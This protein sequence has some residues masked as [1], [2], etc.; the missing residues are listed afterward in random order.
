[1]DP[2][3][4]PKSFVESFMCT[5]REEE[6][7][8]SSENLIIDTSD[9]FNTISNIRKY[10]LFVSFCLIE[11]LFG[12]GFTSLYILYPQ[13]ASE[14]GIVQSQFNLII[15]GAGV[16]GL[17][18]GLSYQFIV[19]FLHRRT[20]LVLFTIGIGISQ[21]YFAFVTLFIRQATLEYILVFIAC[22]FIVSFQT[23]AFNNYLATT[24]KL[25]PETI[26]QKGALLF[27]SL[28][29][30]IM[31]GP[32]GFTWV[33]STTNIFSLPF[34]ITGELYIILGIAIAFLMPKALPE[35]FQK[36]KMSF[37][38]RDL[39]GLRII[40]SIFNM[41]FGYSLNRIISSGLSL[42]LKN[43]LNASTYVIS[44][45]QTTGGLGM[46]ASGLT[47]GILFTYID[48]RVLHILAGMILPG[49]GALLMS[50][51]V[52]PFLGFPNIYCAAFG[53]FLHAFSQMAL[54]PTTNADIIKILSRKYGGEISLAFKDNI[55]T[56][57]AIIP[58]FSWCI[59]PVLSNF[60]YLFM[61]FN[62]MLAVLGAI[63][64]LL[65]VVYLFVS[66]QVKETPFKKRT[67]TLS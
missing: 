4:T 21:I 13:F 27:T 12:I 37:P 31:F 11:V 24:G 61:S 23:V 16:G 52:S 5:G 33:W 55:S 43:N 38:F 46:L 45:V 65:G 28:G 36:K 20:I 30:G 32:M 9:E 18:G 44:L 59:G 41:V 47:T 22:L 62:T 17:I 42:Y 7:A 50:P 3:Q 66:E 48:E 19:R 49:I 39:L 1:M 53:F 63:S 2:A 64:V 35:A 40:A 58:Y 34:F 10:G 54:L 26:A 56:V 29:V 60:F 14:Y 15:S 67:T 8:I 6:E 51:A 25:F 57:M